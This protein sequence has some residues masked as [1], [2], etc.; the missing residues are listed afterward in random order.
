MKKDSFIDLLNDVDDKFISELY[1]ESVNSEP[2]RKTSRAV[3]SW[4]RWGAI[5]AALVLVIFGSVIIH[6][7]HSSPAVVSDGNNS[8]QL[9]S[10]DSSV[11]YENDGSEAV[12]LDINPSIQIKIDPTTDA[13]SS[14]IPLNKDA[15]DLLSS[16][17]IATNELDECIGILLQDLSESNYITPTNNSVLV[18]VVNGDESS[19]V[20]LDNTIQYLQDSAA[21]QHIALSV[22]RQFIPDADT[23]SDFAEEYKISVGKAALIDNLT[24]EI[25]SDSFDYSELAAMNIQTLNLIAEYIGNSTIDRIGYVSG[26]ISEEQIDLIGITDME[27]QNALSYAQEIASNYAS[28]VQANPTMNDPSF[29]DYQLAMEQIMNNGIQEWTIIAKKLND[30][31]SNMTFGMSGGNSS[32]DE[33]NIFERTIEGWFDFWSRFIPQNG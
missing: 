24:K 20:L 32:N 5:A 12:I 19:S 1:E 13:V 31:S 8:G 22:I 6:N 4:T 16:E 2:V 27:V 10:Q 3:V 11:V 14:L 17:Y 15:E 33:K 30:A 25:S 18:S 21:D 23:Y 9:Y 28:L 29:Y 26:A 7:Y